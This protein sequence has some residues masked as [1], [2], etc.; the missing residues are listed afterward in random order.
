MYVFQCD[1]IMLNQWSLSGN[2]ANAPLPVKKWEECIC[3]VRSRSVQKCQSPYFRLN[4]KHSTDSIKHNFAAHQSATQG[5]DSSHLAT[6]KDVEHWLTQL[7]VEKNSY[8]PTGIPLLEFQSRF[9]RETRLHLDPA[10]LGE[11]TFRQVLKRFT[12]LVRVKT[13]NIPGQAANYSNVL[14]SKMAMSSKIKEDALL[15]VITSCL[16]I[17][18]ILDGNR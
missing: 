13:I 1:G 11:S 9:E 17:P 3:T 18:L 10:A 12:H 4:L 14:R 16:L 8:P 2:H 7:Y 6:L 15:E 5:H